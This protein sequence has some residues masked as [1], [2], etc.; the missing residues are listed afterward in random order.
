MDTTKESVSEYYG[1]TLQSSKDLKTT[2]CCPIDSMP[3]FVKP[4]LQNVPNEVQ[5]RFY[6]CGS[7]IPFAIEGKRILDLGCGT[8][9]D[10]FI[11]SQLAGPTGEVIGIDMTDEQLQVANKYLSEFQ[12]KLSNQSSP[13]LFQKGLIEDLQSAGIEDNS[14]DVVVSNC[15]INLSSSKESVF[16]EI[17]R[18]LKPGGELFFSD[19]FTDRRVPE[20]LTHDPILLGEC[21]SGAL[22]IQDFRR[23]LA[24][25]GFQDYRTLSQSKIHIQDP[26]IK[27]K[28]GMIGFI[29]ATVRTFKGNYEDRCEDFG[30]T[31]AYL[32]TIQES[33][34]FFDLDDHHRFITGKP[35]RVCSNTAK[36]LSETRYAKHF[37]VHGDDSVHYGI[38]E[39]C[40]GS[41]QN[42][43]QTFTP[44]TSSCC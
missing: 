3:A 8:G 38:F 28:A 16:K 30:Q 2:A 6:G 5:E 29:S 27:E 15:V 35:V 13:I 10:C 20:P 22:Y 32:G 41:S 23:L 7:P 44:I 37:N 26:E 24:K 42:G 1:K 31:A 9:R 40:S 33:P 21:L 4:L 17:F 11:L 34:D 18:V 14:I 12:T 19:V 25:V 39:D 36:M 43:K